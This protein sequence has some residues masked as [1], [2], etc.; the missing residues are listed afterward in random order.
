MG[1]MD[2][3]GY[4]RITCRLKELITHRGEHIYPKDVE[5]FLR[6]HPLIKDVQVVG[7]PCEKYGEEVVAFIR[8]KEG[9]VLTPQAVQ[10][11]CKG[12]IARWK[13]PK[14]VFFVGSFPTT[15][16]GKIQKSKLRQMAVEMLK[17]QKKPHL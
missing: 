15:T 13:I 14:Y 4:C 2:E 1:V 10:S 6:N 11:F 7:I 16:S 12:Q 8:V 3:N 9:H 17:S 5:C